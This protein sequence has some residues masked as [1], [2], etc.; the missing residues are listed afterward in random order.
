[1]RTLM[2]A[3]VLAAIAGAAQADDLADGIK[4]WESQDFTKAHKLLGKAADAGN[5]EAQLMVGEM[6][7]FGEGVP[8]DAAIA[9]SW[10]R[11]A[12]AGGHKDAT[13]SLNTLKQRGAR[14]QDIAYFVS[15]YKG[16]DVKLE[17]YGCVKP[18]IP[19]ESG[20]QTQ[21]D[22]KQV[23]A[24]YDA[25]SACYEQFGKGLAAAQPAGKAIPPDV[26]KVMSLAELQQARMAMDK[27]YAAIATDS[28]RQAYEIVSSYN[29]WAERTKNYNI[30]M[31]KK[32]DDETQR[33]VRDADHLMERYRNAVGSATTPGRR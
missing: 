13:E 20:V 9:E 18:T 4:A 2:A 3:V 7:G 5:P 15:S 25:W 32:V 8:E 31:S 33:A 10:I 23:R 11:K 29:A 14:K 21:K 26:A 12:Q 28:E 17:K 19:A 24:A 6:Y 27:V 22:I 16:D 1:M 30:A